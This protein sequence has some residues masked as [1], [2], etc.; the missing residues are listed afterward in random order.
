MV[1]GGEVVIRQDLKDGDG[2]GWP[3][4]KVESS[5]MPRSIVLED[6]DAFL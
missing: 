6:F 3:I 2:S 4:G 5:G 1:I